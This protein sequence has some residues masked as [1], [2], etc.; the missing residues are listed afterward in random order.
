MATAK[1]KP[2][3]ILPIAYRPKLADLI[4]LPFTGSQPI[5]SRDP[6]QP[7]TGQEV[8]KYALAALHPNIA[9]PLRLKVSGPFWVGWDLIVKNDYDENPGFEALDEA[10]LRSLWEQ[11]NNLENETFT[12][13]AK[14]ITYDSMVCG[15]SIAEL[16]W[17]KRRADGYQNARSIKVHAPWEFDLWWDDVFR[18]NQL[19]YRRAG[20]WIKREELEYFCIATYPYQA[21]GNYYG[22]SVIVP[23]Y[24][25]VR[26]IEILEQAQSE[27]VRAVSLKAIL[28]Y[29]RAGHADDAKLEQFKQSLFNLDAG[30]LIPLPAT[31][32]EG[33]GLDPIFEIKVLEDRASASGMALISDML[34]RLYKRVTRNMDLPDD[35]GFTTTNVGS[36]AK[37]REE[38]NL[39]MQEI[40]STQEW[41]EGVVNRQILPMLVRYNFPSAFYGTYNLPQFK[42]KTV[43]ENV[44][45]D[46]AA[47]MIQLYQSGL[48]SKAEARAELGYE[49][50]D[51]AA[52][53][54]EQPDQADDAPPSAEPE[55][56]LAQFDKV[57]GRRPGQEAERFQW[58]ASIDEESCPDCIERNGSVATRAEW[59][60]RGLPRG[61]NASGNPATQC[62]DNCRCKVQKVL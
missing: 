22:R 49:A 57:G 44:L 12:N 54:P 17:H 1:P 21:H 2:A 53:D 5:L 62:R 23:V 18:M 19:Y 43:E 7:S 3:Q 9:Q 60:R 61:T 34:E 13:I 41:I 26:L 15:Y 45:A 46:I 48:I 32:K 39:Y 36:L 28:F 38:G 47:P 20:D 51:D 25:D 40:V 52:P 10:I 35:L 8:Y 24:H 42:F 30:A 58:V 4:Q 29:Y 6:A 27:G 37:S 16:T 31:L 11:L 55:T 14:S 33:G 56:Q 50:G 59:E